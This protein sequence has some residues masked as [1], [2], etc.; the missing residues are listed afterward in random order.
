MIQHIVTVGT[1]D[2][3]IMEALDRKD[4]DQNAM[5]EAVKAEIGGIE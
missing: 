1:Q 2:E 4:N 5:I 3:R